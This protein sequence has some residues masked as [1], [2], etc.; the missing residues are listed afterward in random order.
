MI[1]QTMLFN[2]FMTGSLGRLSGKYCRTFRNEPTNGLVFA[3]ELIEGFFRKVSKLGNSSFQVSQLFFDHRSLF[4][5]RSGSRKE[6]LDSLICPESAIL[7]ST[8]RGIG[9]GKKGITSQLG[10]LKT[11]LQFSKYQLSHDRSSFGQSLAVVR[12]SFPKPVSDSVLHE[13]VRVRNRN[14]ARRRNSL[15]EKDHP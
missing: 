9:F 1:Q 8:G 13:S 5:G 7:L 15:S 12:G 4:A 3:Q 2:G 14:E 10:E 11:D 6:L